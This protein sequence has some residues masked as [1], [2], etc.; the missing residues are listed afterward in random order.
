VF[1]RGDLASQ[2]EERVIGIRQNNQG[3]AP[4]ISICLCRGSPSGRER[5][6]DREC[7][8]AEQ[9]PG[10]RPGLYRTSLEHR[11]VGGSQ[12]SVVSTWR[13]VGPRASAIVLQVVR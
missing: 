12:R 5:H 4:C 9:R 7:R 10:V 2:W 8:D 3:H 13:I 6:Q 11:R 1:G